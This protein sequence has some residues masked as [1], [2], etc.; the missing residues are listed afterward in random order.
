MPNSSRDDRSSETQTHSRSSVRPLCA[1]LLRRGLTALPFVALAFAVGC[2]KP[3][4]S[5]DG[6]VATAQW[7]AVSA[8]SLMVNQLGYAP[9]ATKIGVLVGATATTGTVKV[10]NA[11]G[12]VA[13]TGGTT[14]YRA[15]DT[16]SGEAVQHADF[17]GFTTVGTGYK[18]RVSIG[19]TDYDSE[20]FDI[21]NNAYGSDLAKAALKYFNWKRS[22][23]AVA[24]DTTF[25]IAGH[26]ESHMGDAALGAYGGWTTATFDVLGGW[27]DAGDNGK[28]MESHSA[29]T[30]A[31]G[32]LFE[33]TKGVADPSGTKIET[34]NLGLTDSSLPDVLDEI[35]WGTRWVRGAMPNP[36]AHPADIAFTDLVA[37]KCTSNGWPSY[38]VSYTGDTTARSCM[39]PSLSATHGA[40]RNMAMV[41]RLLKSDAAYG[42]V[43]TLVKFPGVNSGANLTAAGYADELWARAQEA[44]YRA[45]GKHP[46]LSEDTTPY[47][48]AKGLLWSDLNMAQSPGFNTGSGAYG[49]EDMK[50]D[51]Y[52]AAAEMYLT[53]CARD[54]ATA[55]AKYKPLVTAHSYYKRV[56]SPCDWGSERMLGDPDK[57]E[58]S[59]ATVSLLSAHDRYCTGTEAL[60][61]ADLDAMRANLRAYASGVL[62]A[63]E[64]Q[65]FP[66][67]AG[68]GKQ[69]VWGSNGAQAGNIMMLTAAYELSEPTAKDKKYLR[70]AARL[71][72]YLLGVNPK[73]ISYVIGFG[74]AAAQYTHDRAMN[75]TGGTVVRGTLV[76]GPHNVDDGLFQVPTS[77]T[78]STL[79]ASGFVALAERWGGANNIADTA[80]ANSGPVLRDRFSATDTTGGAS[81]E[82]GEN[83]GNWNAALAN[84]AWSL[85]LAGQNMGCSTSAECN[86]NNLCTTDSCTSSGVC[87][88]VATVCNDNRSCSVDSCNPA[89]GLCGYDTSACCSSDGDCSDGTSCTEDVCG[90][91]EL[92]S[93]PSRNICCPGVAALTTSVAAASSVEGTGYEAAKAV[94][95]NTSSRWAS[96][97]SDE[98]WLRLDLGSTKFVKR[99]VLNWEA[100]ASASYEVQVADFDA[101]PWTTL[102]ATT[103]GNGG[104]DDLD[105]E[106]GLVPHAGRYVRMLGHT[107]ITPYGH[108]LYEFAAYGDV[109]S[110]LNY[111]VT[112]GDNSCDGTET[113]SSCSADCGTGGGTCTPA[114]CASLGKNCGSVSNGCGGTLSCGSC[115]SPQTCGGGGTPNVCG[116]AAC[117]PETNAAFCSRL[118]KT[119]G[120]VTANDNCGTSRTVTSCGTC[121]SPLTC[122]GG[123]TANV[124]GQAACTPE[125]DAAFCSRLGKACGSVTANDNCGTSR[126]VTS[127]GV[128]NDSNGCT[129][130]A[131]NSGT[132][133]FTNNTAS[134]ADDGNVCTTDVCSAGACTHP[135]GNAGTVC[136]SAGSNATCN[137]GE[138]C[139]GTSTSCPADAF[140]AS[141]T[142]CTG[143]TCNGSG[144][145]S[146]GCVALTCGSGACGSKSDGC[147]GTLNCGTC[148]AGY[149]C[150]SNQCLCT[151]VAAPASLT[152]SAGSEQVALSWPAVT[153]ATSYTLR[154]STTSGGPY[155]DVATG[156]T[157][158]TYVNTLASGSY[159][160]VVAAQSA[161]G[162]SSN[163]MQASAT[164]T[165]APPTTSISSPA[166]NASFTAPGSITIGANASDSSFGGIS[167]VEFYQ[168]TTLL[169]SDTTSPYS[170]SWTGVAAG[171]YSLTS[172]A[173][174]TLNA[175]ATSSAIS[176]TVDAGAVT[177]G[178]TLLS[179]DFQDNNANGWN[180]MKSV[181]TDG[182]LCYDVPAATLS[183]AGLTTWTD[184]TIAARM[185]VVQFGGTSN[186]Y[187]AGIVARYTSSSSYYALA[188]D[189]QSTNKL[190]LRKGTSTI[191]GC[192]D[193][194]AGVTANSW[195]TLKLEVSGGA[196][197][198]LKSYVNN[199]LKQ[200][201]TIS[202]GALTAGSIGVQTVGSNTSARFDDVLVTSP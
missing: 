126:T 130:D 55:V 131:C 138:T 100:A 141:G 35:A 179:D 47:V 197:T 118:G 48:P 11:S 187:R 148:G 24:A 97:F 40:A 6:A 190:T 26:G 172:K 31:L 25:G 63:L 14:T 75:A 189:G 139:N 19:S 151:A 200:T 9:G 7:A 178:G 94:D 41:A 81:W 2:T 105:A 112:C 149:S 137:P 29:A 32:N 201:C 67:H 156:V 133:A 84:A 123:G 111:T 134:C 102:Y 42:T 78:V 136:R 82:C 199:V 69:V 158:T 16:N 135:A 88:N 27:Y 162:T 95:G 188:I 90:T 150:S 34:F 193:V 169:G 176:V 18:L 1:P 73:K 77:P 186:S 104:V 202:S 39:G 124:C 45:T 8:K 74:E 177:T 165:N 57:E 185:K 93:N 3:E 117:T 4:L 20:P 15:A 59:C 50:D 22:G 103:A 164:A 142:A 143:G 170:F 38:P 86:D 98:Q 12:G 89:S 96:T 110:C 198:T 53:A 106:D 182:T 83:A 64:G 85:Q 129:N 116:Q 154:R 109:G 125:T 183:T 37:N 128:C 33:R 163:S 99:V 173:F 60:P 152:A 107:R 79:R 196:T 157:S 194:A 101:G 175:T 61:T 174:D 44:F 195:A 80:C 146:A 76:G 46:S 71:M 68:N 120:S 28:Y 108:S 70:G 43:T 122:G 180:P 167:K 54:D 121:T 62:S 144:S 159:Y 56:D 155:T 184:Q 5:D 113:S 168:G 132:C 17:T 92:C 87:T 30:W 91:N 145:C 181:L 23:M 36:T 160:Y 52:A 119:C 153:G 171:T 191:S 147:G 21:N 140:A 127:C 49:D 65:N 192:A 58:T 72:D 161:C 114:T 51:E 13:W 10:L 66:F 115:T 166:N